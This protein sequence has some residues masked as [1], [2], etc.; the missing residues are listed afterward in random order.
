MVLATILLVLC[1]LVGM[2][3]PIYLRWVAPVS[4]IVVAI[5]FATGNIHVHGLNA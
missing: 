2:F 4:A 1:L 5:L 3:G